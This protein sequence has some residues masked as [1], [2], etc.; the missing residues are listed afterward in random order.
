M[1]S[2]QVPRRT[3]ALLFASAVALCTA[4]VHL[5]AWTFELGVVDGLRTALAGETTATGHGAI[6]ATAAAM[7]LALW[8]ARPNVQFG[9]PPWRRFVVLWRAFAGLAVGGFVVLEILETMHGDHRL[10]DLGPLTQLLAWPVVLPIAATYALA[11]WATAAVLSKGRRPEPYEEVLKRSYAGLV[12]GRVYDAGFRHEDWARAFFAEVMAPALERD[13]GRVAR[14]LEC[15]C[16][17]GFW[18]AEVAALTAGRPRLLDGFDLSADMISQAR[19]RLG[20][21]DVRA[22]VRVGDVLDDAAYE[23]QGGNEYEV[24][25]AYDVVQQLPRAMHPRTVTQMFRHVAPGGWLVVF[26]HDAGSR[27]GRT[28]GFKKLLRR[29]LGLPLVPYHYIHAAYPHLGRLRAGLIR[30]GGLDV[31]VR[32]EREGRHRALVA[33][34]PPG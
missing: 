8:L 29:Y 31:D 26:D 22:D 11:A 30:A 2:V 17:T 6:G 34:R 12:A 13:P 21:A 19:Q 24:V 18:L 15:G 23:G 25:F 20:L 10:T 1:A 3:P 14:I 5:A 7:L 27:Y 9:V 16:G 28:M 33:R 4:I 32:V